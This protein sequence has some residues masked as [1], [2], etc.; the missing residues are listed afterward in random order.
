MYIDVRENRRGNY[1]W[2][3]PRHWQHW[4]QNTEWSQTKQNS[5]NTDIEKMRNMHR[6][7]QQKKTPNKQTNKTG[8]GSRCISF[9][10][11]NCKPTFLTIVLLFS[12]AI[13][14]L[15]F[16]YTLYICKHVLVLIVT[17]ILCKTSNNKIIVELGNKKKKQKQKAK[18]KNMTP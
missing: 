6:A 9:C 15:L 4:A 16:T 13:A 10:I 14:V 17:E 3:I 7:P 8:G 18:T 1:E 12:R 5:H 11:L 2:T